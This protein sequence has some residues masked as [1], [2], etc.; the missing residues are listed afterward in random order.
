MARALY[1]LALCL[2]APVLFARLLWRARRQPEYLRHWSERLGV[3]RGAP[4]EGPLIWVHAVSLGETRAARPLVEALRGRHPDMHILITHMT[5]TGRAASRA[6]FGAGVTIGYL[7]YDYPFALARFLD[8]FRPCLGLIMETEIWPN[9]FAACA[10]RA[11][12][13]ALVNARCSRRSARA[14]ARLPRL[15]REALGALSLVCAQSTADAQRF[16]ALGAPRV[17]VT[18]NLKFDFEPPE[19]Q[20]RAGEALRASIGDRP[21]LL[22]ASTREG[23]E[24]LILDALARAALPAQVLLVFVPRHPQRFDE[25]EKLIR[26]RGL[27]IERRSLARQ[28]AR[29]TKVLLGDSMGELFAYY[30]AADVAF[31]GG[32]LLPLGGQNLIEAC[33]TATPVLVGPHTDNFEEAVRQAIGCDAARRARDAADL[34]EQAAGLLADE[35]ARRAMGEAGRAF[36]ARHRGATRRTLALIEPLARREVTS[37]AAR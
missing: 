16:A 1:T 19:A 3:F 11:I 13:L 10:R 24:A 20:L 12:P 28:V 33:A 4:P 30:A 18:G 31:V 34:L 26:A 22:F 8:R 27:A 5:P 15:S 14:H 25:V 2:A 23:E 36:A 7:P 37:P 17:E 21:V 35:A 6:L 32:S 29:D 9:L